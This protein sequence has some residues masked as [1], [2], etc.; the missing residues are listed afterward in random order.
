MA[1]QSIYASSVEK[2]L[3]GLLGV[4][5]EIKCDKK[6][7]IIRHAFK[8]SKK[9][10]IECSD[11]SFVNNQLLKVKELLP[12]APKINLNLYANS[13]SAFFDLGSILHIPMRLTFFN[14]WGM[15][16]ST[17]LS[18]ISP[19]L[20]HEYG[21][22]VFSEIFAAKYYPTIQKNAK[23]LSNLKVRKQIAYAQGNPNNVVE[24]YELRIEKLT[25]KIKN[26]PER[27][28][29]RMI[30]SYNE[31]FSD[32]IAVLITENRNTIMNALYYNEMTDNDYELI[33][34]RSFTDRGTLLTNRLLNEEHTELAPTREFIGSNFLEEAFKSKEKKIE[35]IQIVINSIDIELE[36]RIKNSLLKR[37]PKVSN[38]GLIK[39]IKELSN[40]SGNRI[41]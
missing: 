3:S 13:P 15:Q 27:E 14:N 31:F 30:S 18:D 10:H 2:Q 26:S 22:A 40:N 4:Q 23:D 38:Q 8:V 20:Y 36:R 1:L 35:L 33:R 25:E 34:M 39:I 5:E 28:I 7:D 6:F 21:H 17:I 24:T 9:D 11:V 19:I 32:L 12:I 16:Y 37:D 29:Q 41:D